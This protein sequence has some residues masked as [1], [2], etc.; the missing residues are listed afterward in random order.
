MEIVSH[1]KIETRDNKLFTDLMIPFQQMVAQVRNEFSSSLLSELSS[2]CH[3]I[4]RTCKG[5]G[6]GLLGG[7][8]IDM[9]L[10]SFLCSRLS[11]C[12]SFHNGESDLKINKYPLS[13]K[14]ISGKSKI[15]LNWS[16]NK[17]KSDDSKWFQC[18]MMIINLKSEQWWKKD[19]TD[20]IHAGI[21]FIPKE[22]CSDII[23]SSNN[24]T[25]TLISPDQLYTMLQF[26]NKHNYMIP[27]PDP[28]PSLTF[29]IENAFTK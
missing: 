27:I 2:K 3:A 11:D 21:Y 18:D 8:I 13:L 28:D 5:D 20:M 14:K 16:K 15:A 22:Y 17:T 25:D 24:K 26:S 6:A 7:C 29:C 1:E 23:L 9:F 19:K 4:S 12:E 10:T